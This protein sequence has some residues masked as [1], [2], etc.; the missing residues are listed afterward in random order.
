MPFVVG[1]RRAFR[2]EDAGSADSGSIGATEDAASG[3]PA[4][5]GGTTWYFAKPS[6]GRRGSAATPR[7]CSPVVEGRDQRVRAG[8]QP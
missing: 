1:V 5:S 4:R 7:S 3:R 2:G 6:K 8:V